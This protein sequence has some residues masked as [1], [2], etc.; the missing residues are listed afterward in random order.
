MTVPLPAGGFHAVTDTAVKVIAE[1]MF[2]LV[3][4]SIKFGKSSILA[5]LYN[6]GILIKKIK[7]KNNLKVQKCQK[8]ASK[9]PKSLCPE[10]KYTSIYTINIEYFSIQIKTAMAVATKAKLESVSVDGGCKCD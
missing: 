8:F 7:I 9:P 6:L 10:S 5:I 4:L 3:D 1:I 2:C